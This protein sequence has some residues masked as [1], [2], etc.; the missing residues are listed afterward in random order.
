MDKLLTSPRLYEDS[1]LGSAREITDR[2]DEYTVNKR[3]PGGFHGTISSKD[4]YF[5]FCRT[6]K[7]WYIWIGL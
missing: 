5:W 2:R 7:E 6:S 4:I 3:N 1:A